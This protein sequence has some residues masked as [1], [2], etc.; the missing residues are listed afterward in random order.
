MNR[1]RWIGLC[2]A[3]CWAALA[4][5]VHAQY[6]VALSGGGPV[7]RSMAGTSTAA[8]IDAIGALFWNPATMSGLKHSEL[9]AG[10]EALMAYP[11]VSSSL[12]ASS[13]GSGLPP[14]P[15]AGKSKSDNATVLLPN[16][17]LV[18]QV[19][20]TNLTL[21]FGLLT[22]AGFTT[23][24]PASSL[25]NPLAANPILTAQPKRG[26]GLGSISA[27]FQLYQITPSASLQLTDHI[28]V[29]GGPVLDFASLHADPFF[30][31]TPNIDGTYPSGEHSPFSLGAGA[32]AG[33]YVTTD[34]CWN[35][36]ASLKTRQWMEKFR[37]NT[38]DATGGPREAV[39]RFDFPMIASVGAS[40][41][42]FD[43]LVL[44]A[45]A[46]LINYKDTAGFDQVGFSPD[47]S[48]RGIGWNNCYAFSMG[49]QYQ[50]TE[51]LSVRLGYSYNTNPEPDRAA[52]FNIAAPTIV[53][54]TVY[55]G[56][57][58]QMSRSLLVSATYIHAFE[59]SIEGQFQTPLG[60]I[61]NSSIKNTV[62]A[63]AI[64]LGFTVRY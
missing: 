52:E 29:G 6:G 13:F 15:L 43:N 61:P 62:S 17:G 38:T 48:V 45:D 54:H 12:P 63:D 20:D 58:W 5:P 37:Y 23:N 40:Y 42:G 26:F 14:I 60:A 10:F 46:R 47:G 30:F 4:R 22:A 33:V 50:A 53:E 25:A 28:A 8:P 1:S 19:E 27:E 64:A 36:G 35:F 2:L 49:A 31:T 34:A 21:G 7:N 59:N 32:Q 39:K 11:T 9:E 18:H 3:L 51:C 44:A 16:V 24:Y 57:S 55:V 56:G 41:T